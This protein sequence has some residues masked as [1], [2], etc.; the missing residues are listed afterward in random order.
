MSTNRIG[1]A[2]VLPLMLAL[3]GCEHIALVGRPHID[4]TGELSRTSRERAVPSDRGRQEIIGTVERIDEARNDIHLRT[5]EGQMIVV[6][7]DSATTVY[8]RERQLRVADLRR[9]DLILLRLDRNSRGEQYAD[10]IRMN[11]RN[12]TGR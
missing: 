8:N 1:V 11:D 6:K 10:L 4:P 3:W 9:G 5:T 12:A 7:Y 2:F